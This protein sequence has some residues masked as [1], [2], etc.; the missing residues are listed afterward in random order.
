MTKNIVDYDDYVSR[1]NKEIFDYSYGKTKDEDVALQVTIL[2][3]ESLWNTMNDG[4]SPEPIDTWL[5]SE[6]E[7]FLK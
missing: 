5:V 1:F 3:F 2:A 7:R 4:F 6:V